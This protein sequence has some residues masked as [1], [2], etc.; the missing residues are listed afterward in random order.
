MRGCAVAEQAFRFPGGLDA[1]GFLAGFWQRR[2]LFCPQALDAGAWRIEPEDLLSVAMED[3]VS[4]RL[5]S[6]QG[7]AFALESGPFAEERL[8]RLPARCWSVLVQAMEVWEPRYHGLIALFGFLPRWRIDDIM[9]SLA[10][11][12]GGVGPHVD[13]YDVFL[14]QVAGRRRWSF[15]GPVSPLVEG[16]PLRL[17]S[18]FVPEEVVVAE[19]GDVLYL[20]PG[21]PHDGVALGDG[22]ITVSI[23][24]RAPGLVDL[25][26]R[27]AEAAAARWQEEV[28]AEPRF[29]DAGRALPADP[30]ELPAGDIARAREVLQAAL[31][32]DSLVARLLGEQVTMPRLPPPPAE[33][34]V[35]PDA[36]LARL[37][38]GERL[39]RWSGSRLAH[40]VLSQEEALLFVDGEALAVTPGLAAWLA[41]RD[42]VAA[43]DLAGRADRAEAAALLAELV[44]RG[45]FGFLR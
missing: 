30:W 4:A 39:E 13:Q 26:D 34:A 40:H 19:P 24:F 14:F 20:P 7:D 12:G 9:I 32:D 45:A 10:G 36:V 3:G 35:A 31:D 21:L 17:L 37:A 43:A 1:A 33:D 8:D 23:G 29:G 6:R 38:A 25:A 41:R 44:N 27:L 5:V 42:A 11:D 22:C 18:R 16:A 2:A 15:G 28:E